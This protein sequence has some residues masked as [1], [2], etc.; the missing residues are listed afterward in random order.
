[1]SA[2]Q[3]K[4]GRLKRFWDRA[5]TT[6]GLGRNLVV[7]AVLFAIG[8][9]FAGYFL[10][11][12]RFN[13][14]WENKRS[15][16]A[17]F[18]ESPAISPGNGQEVR[19]A[20]VE[21][22]DIRS[23]SVTGDGKALVEMRIDNNYPVYDNARVVLRPKS[24]LNEMYIELNPGGPPAHKLPENGRLPVTNSQRPIQFDELFGKF[25]SDTRAALTGLL[26]E[27]DVALA[28]APQDLPKGLREGSRVLGDLQPVTAELGKRRENLARLVTALSQISHATGRDDARLSRLAGSLHS[29]LG[30]VA[31]GDRSLDAALAQ[32][33]ALSDKLRSATGEVGALSGQLDPT[34]DDVKQA[35]GV[36]PGALGRFNKSVGALDRTV[37]FARPVL[38]KARPVV[39]DLR[40]AI[41]DL[42]TSAGNLEPVTERLDP[43][44]SGL[45]PYLT[46][47]QGFVYN[48]N[49][50]VSLTDANRG[51][52]RG[53]VNVTPES[54]PLK[55]LDSPLG[56]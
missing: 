30:T 14:P 3:G 34:L 33:P 44:T 53:Q 20:G 28:H 8:T 50:A 52:L 25:D 2:S 46:D 37:D 42:N 1:V 15:I 29:T 31:G 47:L 17:T 6:P 56:G 51:I 55:A 4:R 54:L 23:A 21:V 32:L 35:S 48:T 11:H 19:I 38:A 27:S 36:L 16:Y 43:V 9:T 26:S 12:E 40:P 18:Q 39:A 13:P 10:S 49:S 5:R 45:L 22:G 24:P 7:M 41:R